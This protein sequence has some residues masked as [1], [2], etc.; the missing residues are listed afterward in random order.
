MNIINIENNK[1]YTYVRS[2]IHLH[3]PVISNN[4]KIQIQRN[5]VFYSNSVHDPNEEMSSS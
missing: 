2:K 3:L 1:S 5:F 4:G